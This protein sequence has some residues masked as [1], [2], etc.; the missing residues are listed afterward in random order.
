MAAE[1]F[2]AV[3]V[4]EN[5]PVYPGFHGIS[6]PN[7]PYS[8]NTG[9]F[10][11]AYLNGISNPASNGSF[12]VGPVTPLWPM[13][14]I[15]IHVA[16]SAGPSHSLSSMNDPA[17]AD[18]IADMNRNAGSNGFI[19]L[20]AFTLQTLPP[21]YAGEAALLNSVEATAASFGFQPF[22]IY[23]VDTST[24]PQSIQ[25]VSLWT[26]SFSAE[27]GNLDGITSLNVTDVGLVPEPSGTFVLFITG[28]GLSAR[29]T[30]SAPI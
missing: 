25:G 17:L 29:R 1:H 4:Q 7:G 3:F 20:T 18:I 21:Q 15:A 14:G 11:M 10:P 23:A 16:D 22:D 24:Q 2:A 13:L 5:D 8:V 6:N 12:F 27:V 19:P 26:L 9:P 28:F 30:R